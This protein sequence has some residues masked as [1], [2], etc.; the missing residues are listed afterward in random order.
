MVEAWFLRIP[1]QRGHVQEA[2]LAQLAAELKVPTEAVRIVRTQLKS[3]RAAE[4]HLR[5]ARHLS[6]Q[7]AT[8]IF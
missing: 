7:V 3:A 2:F 4:S 8:T 1:V 5:I 6:S